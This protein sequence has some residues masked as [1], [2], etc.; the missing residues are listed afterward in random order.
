MSEREIDMKIREPLR[1]EN[2]KYFRLG[3]PYPDG[4]G[5][6]DKRGICVAKDEFCECAVRRTG[7]IGRDALLRELA[8]R[9]TADVRW[10][11][12]R[13]PGDAGVCQ[14]VY[15]TV[16]DVVNAQP[17]ADVREN[18]SCTWRDAHGFLGYECTNC[19]QGID[20]N[21]FLYC[22]WCGAKRK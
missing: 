22:P 11:E 17:D 18:V 20:C 16:L 1:C 14:T 13:N 3:A 12:A 9:E 8:E 4:L 10:C 21:E 6:C 7:Y 19:R 2:C 15:N 5:D